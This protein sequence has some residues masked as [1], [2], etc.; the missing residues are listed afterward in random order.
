VIGDP[1]Q[2]IYGFRGS[3]KRFID[4]F[5]QDYPDAR[6]FELTRSFRCAAPIIKAAGQ[7]TGTSLRGEEKPVD[8]F[9]SEYPTEKSEAEGIARR[10]AALIGGT[11]FFAIDSNA[12][13]DN[14]GGMDGGGTAAPEDCAILIRAGAMAEP[15]IK[16][17]KDHGIPFD[18]TG[19]EPW[20]EEEPVKSLINLLRERQDASFNIPPSAEIKDA[21]E[22]LILNG[23]VKQGK[24]KETPD[25][26]KWLIGLA[27]MCEDIPALI[28]ALSC[29]GAE[30]LPVINRSGV[31]V[32]TI[33][34]S[35]GLEFDHVFVAGLEEGMLPFTLY[36]ESIADSRIEEER[37]ILYVAMTRARKGLNLS[38]ARSRNFRGR[39]L[40][41]GPSRFLGELEKII[42]LLQDRPPAK[43]N[44]QMNLFQ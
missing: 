13:G 37:R 30:G 22:L 24:K 21:W 7:L 20:W 32:M 31:R 11:S 29:S 4:R 34:A 26:V 38:R 44:P 3:D 25:S 17:L 39:I 28:D 27:E 14:A 1:N 18:L 10:I 2:A 40:S 12:A 19:E 5:Q 6:R 8:L 15:V 9:R 36:D 35:K 41:G 23:T 16:A 42:P 33:H 43:K